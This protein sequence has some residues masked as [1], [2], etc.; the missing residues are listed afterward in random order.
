MMKASFRHPRRQKSRF[1]SIKAFS[2]L[3]ILVASGLLAIVGALL[4]SSLSSSLDVKED[5]QAISDRYH[6]IRQGMSR[7]VDEVSMA[8]L[9]KHNDAAEVRMKTGFRGER[10]E[11]HFTAFG[12]VN[13]LEDSKHSDQRELSFFIGADERTGEQALLRREQPDPD[14]EI[15]EGGRTQTLLPYA[16]DLEFQYWDPVTEDWKDTWDT[17]ESATLLRLP[18]RVK[19]KVTVEIEEGYKTTFTTQTAITLIKPIDF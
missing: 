12:Y 10:D 15:D 8:F 11:M 17:E 2:M 16:K 14:D 13:R 1:A 19:I 7:I 5:V 3:E 4:L 18:P 6:L 9:S